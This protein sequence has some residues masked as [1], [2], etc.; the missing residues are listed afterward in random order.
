MRTVPFRSILEG[1]ASRRGLGGDVPVADQLRHGEFAAQRLREGWE[2]E[3][4]PEWT[5]IEQRRFRAEWTATSY[6]AG[7][8][9]W[10]AGTD[11][12]W[13]AA[14][15]VIST[16]V[17]GASAKWVELVSFARYVGLDQPGLTPI[18][19]VRALYRQ[20]PRVSTRPGELP[21]NMVDTGVQ[22]V[23]WTG[24]SV[25]VEFRRRPPVV[26]GREYDPARAYVAGEVAYYATAGECYEA[27]GAT[28]GN[29]PTNATYWARVEFPYVLAEYVKR[30]AAADAL[31]A[32][33]GHDKADAEEAKA[34]THLLQ[35]AHTATASQG[36]F[37]RVA[38]Q[39]Y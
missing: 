24:T 13:Q 14:E 26:S 25:W 27:K 20:N 21:Y 23:S 2:Y 15:S 32:G 36:Q 17:P 31:R 4:W 9:V 18:G 30:A 3:Y 29:L 10:H 8:E 38:V 33:G 6:A 7:A 16:D 22:P 34:Y 35:A 19:E 37:P 28:T 11:L 39:T 5:V 12:Y 1:I